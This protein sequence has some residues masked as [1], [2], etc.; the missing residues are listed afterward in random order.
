MVSVYK[1]PSGESTC[2]CLWPRACQSLV[3]G[4]AGIG[5]CGSVIA[6]PH[7]ADDGKQRMRLPG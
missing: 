7:R 5:G 2:G 3:H 1:G 6:I 4:R